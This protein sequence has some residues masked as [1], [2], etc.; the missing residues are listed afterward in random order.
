[1][2]EP[3]PKTSLHKFNEE[4]SRQTTILLQEQ[5]RHCRKAGLEFRSIGKLA[6]YVSGRIKTHRTS[7]IR[8]PR[9]KVMLLDHI[10]NQPGVISKVSDDTDDVGVLRAKLAHSRVELLTLRRELDRVRAMSKRL[11]DPSR[12]PAI[13]SEERDFANLAMLLVEIVRR[14]AS[15]IAVDFKSRTVLDLAAR[16]SDSTIAGPE[17]AGQW[18]AWLER[19]RFVPTIRSLNELVLESRR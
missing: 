7:L 8:N 5:L 3:R 18:I 9:Y 1:M 16:P 2:R 19:N 14:V 4:R 15:T 13:S 6:K 12:A 10:R 11:E 17:R